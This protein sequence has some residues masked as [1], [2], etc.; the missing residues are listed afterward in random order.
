[1]AGRGPAP[2]PPELRRRRAPAERGEWQDIPAD[3]RIDGDAP[4]LPVR[5]DDRAWRPETREWWERM[6]GKPIATMWERDNPALARLAFLHQKFWGGDATSAD[7]T[8]MRQIEDRHGLNPKGLR[9]LRWRVVDADDP[10]AAEPAPSTSRKAPARKPS[11]A[12]ARRKRALKVIEGG[13]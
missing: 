13:G 2:K 12:Q 8:E 4:E 1:M 3:A 7:G 10:A 9:D 5:N 6:W 11:T